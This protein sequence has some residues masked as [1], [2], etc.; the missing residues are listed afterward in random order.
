MHSPDELHVPKIARAVVG[1]IERRRFL[2]LLLG[3]AVVA[4]FLPGMKHL[5]AD[6][7]HRAFFFSDDP[8]LLEFEAFERRFGN[9]ENVVI[10]VHSESGV[11]DPDTAGLLNEMTEA[12]WKVPEVIRVDSLAN[13]N[14]V[15]SSGDDIMVERFIP[16]DQPLTQELLN[17]RQKIAMAH[18][19]IPNYL[20]SKNGKT[21]LVMARIRPGIE[22][23]PDAKV[24]TLAV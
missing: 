11:F 4:A 19:T 6:F 20:V 16:D 5:S 13:F 7:T 24:I 14:W 17:E 12:L 21:A 15:H 3:L 18:E 22:T 9:D 2:S 23:Q 8:L 10:A 1:F